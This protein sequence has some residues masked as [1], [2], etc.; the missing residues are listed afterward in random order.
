MTTTTLRLIACIAIFTLAAASALAQ[1]WEQ[2]QKITAH[3]VRAD[4]EFGYPV[5]ISPGVAMFGAI[6]DD[7]RGWASG[8]VY[9]FERSDRKLRQLVKLTAS[10][11]VEDDAFGYSIVIGGN[12][13][14]I[15]AI[16]ADEAE[17]ESGS[18]YVFENNDGNW[19]EV[20]KLA[21]DDG[22]EGDRFGKSIAISGNYAL[23]GANLRDDRGSDSGAAYVFQKFDDGWRQV[24]KLTAN[25]GESGDLFGVSVALSGDTALIGAEGDDDLAWNSGAAYVFA[26]VNGVWMQTAKL[27]AVDG[28]AGDDF[29]NSVALE[30]ERALVGSVGDNLGV[31]SAY[32]FEA[33]SG[34]WTQTAKLTAMFGATGDFFGGRVAL[35]G[36]TA[37]IGAEGDRGRVGAA[38]VF[39]NAGAVWSQ[40]AK[41]SADDADSGDEFGTTVALDADM[42]LVGA[43]H[44][45]DHGEYSGAAYVFKRVLAAP[46]CTGL[47]FI[48]EARC[49]ERDGV[50]RVSVVLAHGTP[51]DAYTIALSS[52]DS[53]SSVLDDRGKG[54]ANFKRLPSGDGIA[55]AEWGCG[56]TAEKPYSCP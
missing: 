40:V 3:H 55:T 1:T 50:N 7:E 10:D 51:G 36:D 28:D 16:Y 21:A 18:V 20:A 22:A 37:L 38:Y 15:G 23:V 25:D 45:E 14:L 53:K 44:D 43:R 6:G 12:T 11:G 41:L 49:I 8:A 54:K 39:E 26:R 48:T 46:E 17:P 32:V 30:D 34:V 24:A 2:R 9:V 33:G 47:E 13:T 31:G 19:S 42:A 5:A 56:A 29:G 52:G 27:T 35:L 4:D